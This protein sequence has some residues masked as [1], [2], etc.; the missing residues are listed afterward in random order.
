MGGKEHSLI[1]GRRRNGS[2]YVNGSRPLVG[3]SRTSCPAAQTLAPF[4]ARSTMTRAPEPVRSNTAA[5][6][7]PIKGALSALC[8]VRIRLLLKPQ[9]HAELQHSLIQT[10]PA[11][12]FRA[13][14]RGI[15]SQAPDAAVA[16]EQ[17][18]RDV[19][20]RV[21]EM[22]CI[23]RIESI[24]AKLQP[25]SSVTLKSRKNEA[26]R[27]TVPGPRSVLKPAV[28]KATVG[29]GSKCQRIEPRLTWTSPPVILDVRLD[30]VCTL[31]IARRV[32]RS[33]RS[34]NAEWVSGVGDEEPV[35]LPTRQ[36]SARRSALVQPTLSV[37]ER[38]LNDSCRTEVMR[39]IVFENCLVQVVVLGNVD[40]WSTVA[41]IAA[42]H[43][44]H[45]WTR[46]RQS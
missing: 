31:R 27:F 2:S 16:V 9:V 45:S 39:Q 6:R 13:G 17:H 29:H 36:E 30:L 5:N 40:R 43:A 24:E 25:D 32:Q 42:A 19:G 41:E 20:G 23:G 44:Q 38:Q 26:S 4:G 14:D 10:I 11:D 37:S 12:A 1:T 21:A 15:P 33:A 22:R 3:N 35:H 28:P 7:P 18:V 46:C 8:F 34:R